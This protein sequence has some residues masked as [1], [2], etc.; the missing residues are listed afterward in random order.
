M[1]DKSIRLTIIK[2]IYFV[3]MLVLA[4]F[5]IGRFSGGD[6]ADMS[7]PMAKATLPVVTLVS[8]GK[9]INPLHG[10][11]SDVDLNYLRGT[12]MPVGAG[13]EVG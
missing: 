10:Y 5:I 8:E 2:S 12:I 1:R 4:L 7:A 3:L 13:R 11:I 9:E 6:N